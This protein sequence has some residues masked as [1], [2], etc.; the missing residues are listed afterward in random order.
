MSKKYNNV[1]GGFLMDEKNHEILCQYEVKVFTTYRGRGSIICETD[2]G[3]M[4]LREFTGSVNRI[5]FEYDVKNNLIEKGYRNVDQY[6]RNVNGELL[7]EDKFGN[8][9]IL[10]NWFDAR[11]CDLSNKEEIFDAANNLAN[12]HKLMRNIPIDE[13][14]IKYNTFTNLG[15]SLE[16]HSKELKKVKGY[17]NN[18]KKKNEFEVRFL[19]CF[20]EFY[21]KGK[22]AL[23]LLDNSRYLDLFNEAINEKT[24]CH[25]SY[26]HHNVLM[27]NNDIATTN[28]EK[29][30]INVQIMDLYQY[31]RKV[32][33]KNYWNVELGNEII[34][35]Y[36]RV[37]PLEKEEVESLYIMLLFP[38]K[39]W[40][41]TNYYY[42]SRKSFLPKRNTE[43]LC[44]LQVQSVDKDNFLES[45]RMNIK[46]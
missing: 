22:E 1:L 43:K 14:R 19:C 34:E 45:L 24:V 17:I 42:N 41:I 2:K 18:K 36:D 13:E 9:F 28:F 29:V 33:E 20:N 4:Q 39:F 8:K 31:L 44:T 40:K 37:K 35:E 25:G 46:L 23:D 38:E 16:K 26:N 21:N 12:L 30:N 3:R 11:E 10:K 32:M 5:E 15:D 7:T 27:L 6:I